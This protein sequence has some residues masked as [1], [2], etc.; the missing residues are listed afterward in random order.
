[1]GQTVQL[2]PD[3]ATTDQLR[4][5]LDKQDITLRRL[6]GHVRTPYT[7]LSRFLSLKGAIIPDL[8]RE[9]LAA[10]EAIKAERK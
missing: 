6:A 4:D 5:V 10:V 3:T 9:V 7:N 1:M 2:D 8:N